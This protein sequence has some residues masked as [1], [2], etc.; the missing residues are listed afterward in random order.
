L[1]DTSRVLSDPAFQ[2]FIKRL[3]ADSEDPL[4]TALTASLMRR[5]GSPGADAKEIPAARELATALL[6]EGKLTNEQFA[7][8]FKADTRADNFEIWSLIEKSV[9]TGKGSPFAEELRRV[10]IEGMVTANAPKAMD[11]LAKKSDAQGIVDLTIA[12]E[13]WAL[14]DPVKAAEWYQN[15]RGSISPAQG[16]GVALAFYRLSAESGDTESAKRWAG[17][18]S[19]EDL[20]KRT[21]GTATKGGH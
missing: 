2:E 6:S 21:L 5:L 20:R 10:V 8:V 9:K 14:V 19:N 16:D 18:I 11:T 17:E 12:I 13:K 7:L 4:G 1:A 3:A 15:Q